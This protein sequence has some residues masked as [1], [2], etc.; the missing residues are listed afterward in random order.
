MAKG[1]TEAEVLQ[2]AAEAAVDMA[3]FYQQDFINYRGCG[4]DTEELYT[5][6]VARWCCEHLDLFSA[7]PQITR[8]ASYKTRGHDGIADHA[9]SNR[10][11][12]LIAMS[13]FRQRE[14][15]RLGWVLDYQTPLK[16]K[17]SENAGKIDLLAWDGSV[18]RILELKKPDSQETMLRCALE[19][20]TYL[21]TVDR[22]KLLRDFGLPEGAYV[23]ACPLVF[24]H[25]A[26]WKELQEDRPNLKKLMS[27][28]D[29]KAFFLKEENGHY[30][31]EG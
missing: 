25:G 2:K 11:E 22:K 9:R 5:E 15:P 21:R 24:L 26:Q 19:G 12:E 27:L 1:Y 28:L 20:I 4:M 10:E 3:G 30:I 14:L 16:N 17:R 13:I 7:I 23:K 8:E 29:C 31:A 6:I 18:L